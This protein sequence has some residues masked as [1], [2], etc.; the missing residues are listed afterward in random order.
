MASANAA[1]FPRCPN[2]LLASFSPNPLAWSSEKIS[3]NERKFPF[4]SRVSTP[5]IR[6]LLDILFKTIPSPVPVISA[7]PIE[8]ITASIADIASVKLIPI[9]PAA[10]PTNFKASAILESVRGDWLLALLKIAV[11]C[12]ASSTD[13]LKFVIVEPNRSAAIPISTPCEIAKFAT[14]ETVAKISFA[15]VPRC[16]KSVIAVAASFA[17]IGN[18]APISRAFCVSSSSSWPVAP[19]ITFTLVI[20]ASN[21][22][23]IANAEVINVPILVITEPSFAAIPANTKP[24]PD[25]KCSLTLS[26]FSAISTNFSFNVLF[27]FSAACSILPANFDVSKFMTMLILLPCNSLIAF[28]AFCAASTACELSPLITIFTPS[29]SGIFPLTSYH[30]QNFLHPIRRH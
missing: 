23:P 13:I 1:N 28:W 12:A 18:V 6:A 30:S 19:E 26:K 14:S 10:G 22:P 8:L 29:S 24:K 21:P 2:S 25:S 3:D 16:A 27:V 7:L 5:I 9:A 17:E 4:M 11:T 15:L 20:C